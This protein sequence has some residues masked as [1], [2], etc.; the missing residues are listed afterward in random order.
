MDLIRHAIYKKLNGGS[1]GGS[2][3]A[4]WNASEG[5]HGYVKN[6]THWVESEF[7]T[8]IE[9]QTVNTEYDR[10]NA[11]GEVQLS[12]PLVGG[13]TYVVS[14]N[15]EQ[16]ECVAF[17]NGVDVHIGGD[18]FPFTISHNYEWCGLFTP[19]AGTYT[20]KVTC[21]ADT[22]H[23][24]DKKFL[25][26]D[27]GGGV[28]V[29]E[30]DWDTSKVITPLND[31]RDAWLNSKPIVIFWKEDYVTNMYTFKDGAVDEDGNFSY[32][33]FGK[34]SDFS[35]VRIAITSDGNFTYTLFDVSMSSGGK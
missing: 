32:A 33:S 26:D 16:F 12:H 1:G 6:R 9:E 17:D 8:N 30:L 13:N 21:K 10:Y 31:I 5:E 4:D 34:L 15:G 19:D 35:Y 11:S 23:K 18:G 27:I 20:L 14:F 2:G 25:P 24:L 29:V 7:I 3:G 28:F 22:V